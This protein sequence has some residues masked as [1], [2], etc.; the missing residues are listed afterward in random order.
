[1]KLKSTGTKRTAS[2]AAISNAKDSTIKSGRRYPHLAVCVR[3]NG[4]E[5]S[6]LLGK[7]YRIIKP[8]ANDPEDLV[9]VIDEDDEDYLYSAEWFIPIDL[10][11]SSRKS[12]LHAISQ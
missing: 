8:M 4:N 1:M 11:P 7:A 2:V 3:N 9:R 10:P 6:L 5:A 12:I